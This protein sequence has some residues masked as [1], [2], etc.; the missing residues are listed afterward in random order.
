MSILEPLRLFIVGSRDISRLGFLWRTFVF[1]V[2][3]PE[4]VNLISPNLFDTV[5]SQPILVMLL[6][7]IAMLVS[8]TGTI[9]AFIGRLNDLDMSGWWLLLILFPPIFVL[10]WFYLLLKP[11]AN[12]MKN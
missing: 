9:C 7:S 5:G 8:V 6:V 12:G 1:T 11:R 4:S 10:L 2:S 3:V